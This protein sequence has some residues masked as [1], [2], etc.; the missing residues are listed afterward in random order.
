MKKKIV[1][2]KVGGFEVIVTANWLTRLGF[3]RVADQTFKRVT[4]SQEENKT[5]VTNNSH[6]GKSRAILFLRARE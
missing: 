2:F 4:S 1:C 3:G 5:G 6:T